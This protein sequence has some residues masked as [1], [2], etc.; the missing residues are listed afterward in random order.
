MEIAKFLVARGADPNIKDRSRKTPL[1]KAAQLGSYEVLKYLVE[2]V[3]DV[4][5]RLV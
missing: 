4:N 5:T 1:H 3:S 2:L